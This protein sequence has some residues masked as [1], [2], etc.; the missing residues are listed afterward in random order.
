MTLSFA[1]EKAWNEHWQDMT[2][3]PKQRLQFIQDVIGD[4]KLKSITGADVNKIR[5]ALKKKGLKPSSVNRYLTNFKTLLNMARS[6]KVPVIKLTR[7]EQHRIRTF[8]RTEE[9]MIIREFRKRARKCTKEN[10]YMTTAH[11]VRLMIDTGM[12]T[13]EALRITSKHVDL[14]KNRITISSDIAKSKKARYIP[15][16]K[17]AQKILRKRLEEVEQGARLYPFEDKFLG[18]QFRKLR[19]WLQID[20]EQFVP[21]TYASHLCK[22]S[23]GRWSV[24]VCLQGTYGTCGPENHDEIHSSVWELT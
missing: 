1:I 15:L 24:S 12:R 10:S 11:L 6:C 2:D 8:S 7:E 9:A 17:R 19:E 14:E 21:H 5:V 23:S 3:N 20:D 22:P 4:K 18:H 16:T 13:G